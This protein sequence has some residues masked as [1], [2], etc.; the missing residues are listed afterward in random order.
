[1]TCCLCFCLG[2]LLTYFCISVFFLLFPMFHKKKKLNKAIKKTLNSKPFLI[3]GH[4]G[5]LSEH[6]ENTM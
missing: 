3:F 6:P 1:M 4:R 5:G 2:V